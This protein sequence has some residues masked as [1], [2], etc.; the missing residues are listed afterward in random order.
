MRWTYRTLQVPQSWGTGAFMPIPAQS[1]TASFNGQNEVI[2]APGT[3][4]V[5]SPR[6]PALSDGELGGPFNQPS[7]VSPNVFYPSLYHVVINRTMTFN[8]LGTGLTRGND[9]PAPVAAIA[10]NAIPGNFSHR[11]R[12]GGR[13]VTRAT[14]P[15]TQ[16]RD[17][18]GKK[19]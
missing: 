2:G 3:V 19:S 11:V 10:P 4:A 12:V 7:S 13:T 9:H 8:G 16:W 1:S 14:R 17:Y 6:P 15:F 5:P 18:S